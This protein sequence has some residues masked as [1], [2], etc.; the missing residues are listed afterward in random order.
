MVAQVQSDNSET[1]ESNKIGN[2]QA[3][4]LFAVIALPVVLVMVIFKTGIGMPSSTI[5][6]GIMLSP[7]K[8]VSFVSSVDSD[9]EAFL[10]TGKKW[11]LLIPYQQDCD[12]SCMENLYLT[13]QVHIRLGE[14]ARRVERV[15]MSFSPKDKQ[16]EAL[17]KEHPR[18]RVIDIKKAEYSDWL[19]KSSLAAENDLLRHYFLVDES[20]FAMMAYHSQHEGN[21]LLKDIKRVLKF[22][23]EG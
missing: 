6:E 18:L 1:T 19:V 20:G 7:A 3:V 23:S 4:L 9:G 13:R 21:Q 5:N 10:A 8:Q 12:S 15:L 11:R 2:W 17:L 16:L 22:T 14:K